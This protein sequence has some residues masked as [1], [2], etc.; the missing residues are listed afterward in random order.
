MGPFD[1]D[2]KGVRAS[3][4][5]LPDLVQGEQVALVIFGYD[6][7]QWPSL[8]KVPEYYNRGIR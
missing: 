4:C 1:D 2:E 8:K 3:A 5:K 7:K 6:E